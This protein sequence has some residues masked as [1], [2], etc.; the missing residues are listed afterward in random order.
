MAR[1][2]ILDVTLPEGSDFGS[3]HPG[4]NSLVLDGLRALARGRGEM[5]IYVYGE[6]GTGKTHLLQ[7][8]CHE[9]AQRGRRAAYLPR[10]LLA[11]AGARSLDGLDA[12]DVVC[13]DGVGAL[14][15][16][17]EGEM[18]LFN[19]INDARARGTQLVLSDR[20]SPRALSS[21]LSDLASRLVWGPVFQL[22]PMDDDAKCALLVAWAR[23]RGFELPR[24]VAE[25]LL[26]TCPRDLP[27]LLA[28]AQRLERES[29]G[30]QRRITLPFA[31][32]VTRA[33]EDA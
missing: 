15:G 8:V 23:R 24:E 19:L 33:G 11:G 27:S 28:Q 32:A 22:A 5:Q 20:Q 14:C 7:A 26:R 2:L 25:Y 10:V 9:A 3:F 12:L 17:P 21:G 13:L 18:A 30:Q 1:Q 4:A 29:L 16:S 31:R 6:A